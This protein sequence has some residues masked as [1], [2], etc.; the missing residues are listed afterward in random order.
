MAWDLGDEAARQMSPGVDDGA[1]VDD[2]ASVA[3]ECRCALTV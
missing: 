1:E 2:G 3:A